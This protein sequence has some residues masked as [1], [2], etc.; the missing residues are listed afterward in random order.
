MGTWEFSKTDVL[1]DVDRDCDVDLSDF[2][3]LQSCWGMG[4]NS[5]GCATSDV[6]GN[7]NVSIEDYLVFKTKM[8]GPQY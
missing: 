4:I 6:D 5:D 3:V 8:E 7:G 2:A 1:P